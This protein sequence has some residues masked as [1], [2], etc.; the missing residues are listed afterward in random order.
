MNEEHVC[1][2]CGAPA[3][4]QL[5]NGKWCCHQY[6]TQCPEIRMK[7]SLAGNHHPPANSRKGQT[8]ETNPS[9]AKT[10]QKLK[11]GYASGR[12]VS[13]TK[14]KP[15]TWL[16]RKHTAETKAKMSATHKTICYGKSIWATQ[17]EKRKSYAEQYF[18]QIFTDAKFNYHVDRYFLDFAWPDKKIYI[19]ID[20]EQHYNDPKVIEHD[21]V[22]T[23]RLAEL[24]WKCAVRI[25]W[26][27]FKALSKDTQQRYI[28]EC[29]DMV[30]L[31]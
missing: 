25:R 10:A 26:S 16:G 1:A 29:L 17:I 18:L 7:N 22:R 15:G 27:K 28:Q 19:E 31:I 4:Y 2:Y 21:K 8:K 11:E 6:I 3:T 24:G 12:I 20:G 30:N 9:I 23:N 5:K 13:H 14:G